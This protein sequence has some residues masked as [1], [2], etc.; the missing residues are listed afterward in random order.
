MFLGAH[1][2]RQFGKVLGG[3]LLAGSRLSAPPVHFPSKWPG[4][5]K[6]TPFSAGGSHH[7]AG[8]LLTLCRLT[9]RAKSLGHSGGGSWREESAPAGRV[10]PE[11]GKYLGS[12]RDQSAFVVDLPSEDSEP[13]SAGGLVAE[14]ES[15]LGT[16]AEITEHARF[17]LVVPAR[18]SLFTHC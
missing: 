15:S 17:S 16:I 6:G 8:C 12:D 5:R 7:R 2:S 11:P 14:S 3:T 1:S 10:D 9:C 13:P 4:K 18:P